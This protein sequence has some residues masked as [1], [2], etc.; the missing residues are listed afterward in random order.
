VN[1]EE[2]II[3]GERSDQERDPGKKEAMKSSVKSPR[4]QKLPQKRTG[5]R[6]LFAELSEGIE[7][8]AHARHGKRTLR[9]HSVEQ[10]LTVR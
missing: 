1:A 5:K 4:D 7:A 10:K 9:T 3:I 6:D 8:L 2:M